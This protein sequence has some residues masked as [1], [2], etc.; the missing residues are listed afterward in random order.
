MLGLGGGGAPQPE[1]VPPGPPAGGGPQPVDPFVSSPPPQSPTRARRDPHPVPRS[2]KERPCWS[3]SSFWEILHVN[4][5][6]SS[7]GMF[8]VV[9]LLVGEEREEEEGRAPW[10]D[11]VEEQSF[12]LVSWKQNKIIQWQFEFQISGD[13]KSD[14]LKSWNSQI[15]D[16]LQ[17]GFWLIQISNGQDYSS[18]ALVPTIRKLE[19]MGAKIMLL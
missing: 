10:R 18:K 4:M 19:I 13:L 9:L 12:A 6:A 5:V 8:W 14:L 3:W 11:P 15:L 16:F 1:F 17:I 2:L 7:F